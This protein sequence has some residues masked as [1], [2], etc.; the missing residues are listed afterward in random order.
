MKQPPSNP[1][2]F[3][4]FVTPSGPPMNPSALQ[5]PTGTY[6]GASLPTVT[7][8]VAQ[9]GPRTAQNPVLPS[10]PGLSSTLPHSRT[11]SSAPQ[12]SV[13]PSVQSVPSL[14]QVQAGQPQMYFPIQPLLSN[15]TSVPY[16]LSSPV[17]V[18]PYATLQLNIPN[19]DPNNPEAAASLTRS[20]DQYNQQL[21]RSQ[22]DQAQQSAQVAGC[23]VQLLRDQLTISDPPA[24]ECQS[25]TVRTSSML[26]STIATSR[27]EDH[28][29]DTAEHHTRECV[30]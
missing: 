8:G 7:E 19:V 25:R 20:L 4:S 23:Q 30:Y 14:D 13:F 11:F 26:G 12:Q 6:P 9:Q 17:M 1:V 2:P 5:Y 29:R 21:I 15:S 28:E 24:V 18:S 16:G 10:Y 3:D 22:L 27:V